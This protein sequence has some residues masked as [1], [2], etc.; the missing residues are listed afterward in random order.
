MIN[1]NY[2]IKGHPGL[3]SAGPFVF[4]LLLR[5]TFVFDLSSSM[6]DIVSIT[7]SHIFPYLFFFF[8]KNINIL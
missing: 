2:I 6:S 8:L 5:K 7:L 3:G 4:D 1:L